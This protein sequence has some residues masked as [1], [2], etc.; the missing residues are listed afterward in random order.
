MLHIFITLWPK[1]LPNSKAIKQQ[2]LV[3][4]NSHIS[5]LIAN[6]QNKCSL[7]VFPSDQNLLVIKIQYFQPVPDAQ[8]LTLSSQIKMHALIVS[9]RL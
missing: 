8:W 2:E 4:I 5:S 3:M 6:G 7:A 1:S 9:I